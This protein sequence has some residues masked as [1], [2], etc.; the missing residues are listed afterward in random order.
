MGSNV[1][2]STL[3]QQF[4]APAAAAITAGDLV[5]NLESGY[6]NSTQTSLSIDQSNKTTAP[7][8]AI[9]AVANLNPSGTYGDNN[10]FWGSTSAL[11]GN[12]NFV[13][14]YVGDGT[15]GTTNINLVIANTINTPVATITVSDSS[16][17]YY[18]VKKLNSSSFVVAWQQSGTLRFAIYSNTGTT[19]K[20]ATTIA[21]VTNSGD[22]YWNFG[23]LT[24]GN[25]V[26]SWYDSGGGANYAIYDSTGTSVLAST[27]IEAGAAPRYIAVL[28]LSSGGFVI[29]YYRTAA[30]VNYKFARYNSSGTLQGSLTTLSGTNGTWTA[31]AVQTDANL[32][33]E[34]TNGNL[35]FQKP[36]TG[37]YPF[38][39]VY[40]STGTLVRA[41][42]DFSGQATTYNL[43]NV[44]AA[45]C[46]TEYGFAVVGS[47]NSSNRYL[48]TYD[49]TGAVL[50]YRTAINITLTAIANSGNSGGLLFN[51]GAAGFAYF[52]S[53]NTAT[54]TP[55]SIQLAAF[56]SNGNTRGSIINLGG[57]ASTNQFTN[58]SVISMPDG[59]LIPSY[60]FNNT[61]IQNGTY[62]SI[63]T[64]VLGVAQNT[65]SASQNCTVYTQGT[66]AI[67][68]TIPAGGQF[69][70]RTATV[71]GTKGTV[72]G[73]SAIL[74][75]IY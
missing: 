36:S 1:I 15:T 21:T 29:Y 22:T 48:N 3:P 49:F 31:S 12:G 75:G 74:Q 28:P 24:N 58:M 19:I 34:L 51:L 56:Y 17:S 67:N 53:A 27:V 57:G 30:T 65:V 60:R 39:Y 9:T 37:N 63:R 61:T 68:Q 44:C 13:T 5:V 7:L 47:G 6:I 4:V 55:Y 10:Q 72:V 54:C 18:R 8:G 23:C 35:L 66:F 64:S 20:A 70:Q 26:F 43:A 62:A 46:A 25:V 40:D 33:I 2:N 52:S 14:A 45:I 41:S 59:I 11:L 16:I 69:D 73:T 38:G 42:I 71:P 32:A 50:R